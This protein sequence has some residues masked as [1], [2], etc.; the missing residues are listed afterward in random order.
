[1]RSGSTP[2]ALDG[3]ERVSV[4]VK[5]DVDTGAA[6]VALAVTAQVGGPTT[7]LPPC[8]V[9]RGLVA[10]A[11]GYNSYTATA[12][13]VPLAFAVATV[14]AAATF[15]FTFACAFVSVFAFPRVRPGRPGL[16][17]RKDD[18]PTETLVQ[19]EPRAG[20][21]GGGTWILKD[22]CAVPAE[23]LTQ[24]ILPPS[25]TSGVQRSDGSHWSGAQV[26]E[27]QC[28][29]GGADSEP[30]TAFRQPLDSEGE[31]EPPVSPSTQLTATVVGMRDRFGQAVCDFSSQRET[32]SSARSD[33]SE[34]VMELSTPKI[35]SISARSEV[36][37]AT[38]H[39]IDSLERNRSSA[40]TGQG[41]YLRLPSA[42]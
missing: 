11:G 1:M 33:G 42:A 18:R 21:L 23:P 40:S 16:L 36:R 6:C 39:T 19:R 7:T 3:F 38:Q 27:G 17:G 2:D 26:W 22:R 32:G 5:Y 14:F 41:P 35:L 4:S 31:D 37:G 25:L 29:L 28:T 12:A 15:A 13:V 30:D 34:L 20:S 10:R 8:G 9:G 24:R